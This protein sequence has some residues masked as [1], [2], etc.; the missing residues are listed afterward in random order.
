MDSDPVFPR[1]AQSKQAAAPSAH[2]W[3]LPGCGAV[4]S[5]YQPEYQTSP[6]ETHAVDAVAPRQLLQCSATV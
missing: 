4:P 2:E 6:R 1:P 3:W 5:A